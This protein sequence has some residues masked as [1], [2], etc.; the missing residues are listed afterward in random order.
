MRRTLSRAIT[1]ICAFWI[2]FDTASAQTNISDNRHGDRNGSMP[3]PFARRQVGRAH[4]VGFS[5]MPASRRTAIGNFSVFA[6]TPMAPNPPVVGSGSLG[7]LTK[8]T[9]FSSNS[10]IGNSTIFEDKFGMVGIGTDTPTSRLTVSGMIETLGGGLKFP[11]GT[12]QTTS[13]SGALFSIFHNS[14]LTGNGTAGAAL[15]VAVPLNLSGAVESSGTVNVSNTAA[16]AGDGLRVSGGDTVGGQAGFGVT[17][18]GGYSDSS[19]GG[20]GVSANG[21]ASNSAEGGSGVTALGGDSIGGFGGRGVRAFGGH[22]ANGNGGSGTQATGGDVG[23]GVGKG[24]IGVVAT[25]GSSN[26]GS[27]GDGVIAFKGTG[28]L[29]DGL[30]GD[31]FGDVE[32]SGMLSKGGGSF[33]IDHPLDPENRYLYHSFVESPDM[34]NIYDGNVVTDANGEATVELPAYFEALNRDFRYQ[35]TVVDT[36]AQAIVAK[37]IKDN[38]FVIRTSAP[39]VEVS[40][41][42]TG[43][44]QDAW[45]NK[46]RIRAEVEK[47]ERER[48]YY[49]HPEAYSQPQ[50][51]G[52]DWA[53]NP[54]VM[55]QR[56]VAR[57]RASQKRR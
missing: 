45:A 52:A 25:G 24:G 34:K 38:R 12:I 20:L 36:F 32:V 49:V 19:T 56:K 37:K 57:E 18:F 6:I 23:I 21:G 48:G 31:F 14:T 16:E 10:V 44:R 11:D 35:L 51:R 46:N 33:K 50:E 2:C 7:R 26:N 42:V 39:G 15:G 27:G 17:A 41:Q 3:T 54:E 9:G 55:N 22:S 4:P 53:R 13:A 30:A 1:L 43:I 28:P 8:W 5:L 47:P 40:W 29:G